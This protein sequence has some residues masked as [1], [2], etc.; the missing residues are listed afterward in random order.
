MAVTAAVLKRLIAQEL[1][2]VADERVQAHIRSLLVEPA[3]ILRDWNY[4]KP[5]QH[6]LV[7]AS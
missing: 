4:G 3:P 7:G 1:E 2:G 6:M 5:G